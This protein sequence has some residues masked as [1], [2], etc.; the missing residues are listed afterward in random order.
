MVFARNPGEDMNQEKRTWRAP[1][2]IDVG[3]VVDVTEG[4]SS[5]VR[6]NPGSDS[7]SYNESRYNADEVD[8]EQH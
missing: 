5:N 2:L 8:L 7:P 6:D 3:D 4:M 1:E